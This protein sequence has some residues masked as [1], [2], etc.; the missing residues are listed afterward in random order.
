MAYKIISNITT[1]DNFIVDMINFAVSHAGFTNNGSFT[2][3]GGRT[4]RVISRT[5]ESLTTYWYFYARSSSTVNATFFPGEHLVSKMMSVA[6]TAANFLS[7]TV[8]AN[9]RN[10]MTTFYSAGAVTYTGAHLFSNTNNDAVLAVLEVQPGI[11]THINFGNIKK[12]FT[13][14]GGEFLTSFAAF[15]IGG[16]YEVPDSGNN[17]TRLPLSDHSMS[18]G[19]STTLPNLFRYKDVSATGGQEEFPFFNSSS[20]SGSTYIACGSVPTYGPLEF[21]SITSSTYTW[22]MYGRLVKQSPNP[23]N[24]RAP[25]LPCLVGWKS[26]T[27]GTNN[28]IAGTIPDVGV[29]NISNLDAKEI[30]DTTW[31]VFPIGQKFGNNGDASVNNQVGLAI[32]RVGSEV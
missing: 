1:L 22:R 31:Q 7:N 2:A 11:F 19:G 10:E 6:P 24:L 12:E 27:T 9:L 8:G 32:Q 28:T 3:D 21:P 20:S 30:V 15:K 23:F 26:T 17:R 25:I 4:I 13:F 14:T 18:V 29:V 16:S 5:R